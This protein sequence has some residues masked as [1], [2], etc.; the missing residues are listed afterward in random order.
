[1]PMTVAAAVVHSAQI[2]SGIRHS[3]RSFTMLS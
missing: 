3:E 2:E 1:V